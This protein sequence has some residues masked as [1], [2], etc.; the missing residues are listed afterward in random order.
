MHVEESVSES[1]EA[2]EQTDRPLAKPTKHIVCV[3]N[4]SERYC[5]LY[6][7]ILNLCKV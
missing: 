5:M 1:V 2:G 7:L 4:N 3:A 6:I